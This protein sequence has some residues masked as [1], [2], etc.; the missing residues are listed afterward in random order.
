MV[1]VR[2]TVPRVLVALTT[3][4]MIAGNIAATTLP[5]F[6]RST[7]EISDLYKVLVTPAGYVFSIWGLI[8]LAMIVYSGAQFVEPLRSSTLPER[9]APWIVVSNIANVTW[10]FLWHA[11]LIEWTVPVMLVLL[12]SLIGAYLVAHDDGY[13]EPSNLERWGARAPM[14]LYLG[15]VSVATI[16]NVSNLLEAV[17][18]DGF[19][20]PDSTWALAVLAV[21]ALIAA[22]GLLLRGDIVFAGVFV[23]AYAG[24]AVE[25]TPGLLTISAGALAAIIAVGAALTLVVRGRLASSG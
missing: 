23:W 4:G 8:Y 3:A 12:G 7:G 11:L 22:L 14:S 18:W 13:G 2:R 19:G 24:I 17:A 25:T 6:G 9:M 1:V 20:V 5:L 10:L 15:W 21:G 16:A